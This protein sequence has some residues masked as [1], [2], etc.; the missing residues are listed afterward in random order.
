VATYE[1]FL[2]VVVAVVFGAASPLKAA[3]AAAPVYRVDHVVD[4]DTIGSG[5]GSMFGSFR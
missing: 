1:G 4:G 5:T 3:P 2:P